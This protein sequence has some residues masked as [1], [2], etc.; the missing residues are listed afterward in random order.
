[1]KALSAAVSRVP[2]RR[3]RSPRATEGR[4]LLAGC[5]ALV[6][7]ACVWLALRLEDAVSRFDTLAYLLSD[8]AGKLALLRESL[9]IGGAL[10]ALLAGLALM[11]WRLAS[12]GLGVFLLALAGLAGPLARQCFAAERGLEESLIYRLRGL[13]D[14]GLVGGCFLLF[15]SLLPGILAAGPGRVERMASRLV[16][17]SKSR[18][19]EM[20]PAAR[21]AL[22]AAAALVAA[23]LVGRGVLKDFPNSSDENSYLTQARIFASGRL[24]VPAPPHPESFRARSFVMDTQNGRYFAKAFPGWPVF[25]SLGVAAGFPW[26]VNPLLSAVTFIL[27]GWVAA[28]M[29]GPETELSALLLFGATPFFLFNAA[30]YFNHPL[31]LLLLMVFLA[32]VLQIHTA[33]GV[34]WAAL[35]GASAGAAFTVRPASALL[36]TAPFLAWLILRWVRERRWTSLLAALL[37]MAACAALIGIYNGILFGAPWRTGYQAYDPADIRPGFGPD[38]FFITGWWLVKVA[39]WTLPGSLAGLWFLTR[40]RGVREWFRRE[41]MEALMAG[42]LLLHVVGHLVFQNKGSN[43]YGPRYYYDGFGFLA[44][45]LAA[46]WKRLPE[47]LGGAG[48]Q[49]KMRRGRELVLSGALALTLLLTVPLLLFHYSDKVAH[50]RDVFTRVEESGLSSALVLL[51][52]GS[53]RMPP[54]DLLRNPLDFRS[55]VV[56]A[57]D[58]GQEASR[59]LAALYPDRPALSYT[60]DP[61]RRV[62]RLEPLKGEGTP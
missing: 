31:T 28:R 47:T 48:G 20:L 55:G 33:K 59:Q 6:G 60:Y 56:Y 45:L 32:A 9:L 62:S 36:L 25:L 29:L 38:N 2:A 46:G 40:G 22:L 19:T 15:L 14:V 39:L 17:R 35:A 8:P 41:P 50:N 4:Y 54:G 24:W 34:G 61:Y 53:G 51:R 11:S 18:F 16:R 52:T 44:L 43:E 42:A 30:S 7:L 37:P 27:L 58:L 21:R 26:L 1:M 13:S 49:S 10:F 3:V 5:L 12:G 57:R 23:L